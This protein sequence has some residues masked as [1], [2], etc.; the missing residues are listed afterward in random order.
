M[1]VNWYNIINKDD[2]LALD[3]PSKEITVFLTG[4]GQRTI[5]ITSG[6]KVSVLYNDVFLSLELNGKN[7]F[8]FDGHAVYLDSN[9]DIWLGV[10][11]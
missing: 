7:P 11:I 4:I 5:L 10:E 9:N 3:L 2:F 8:E 1:N 6:E